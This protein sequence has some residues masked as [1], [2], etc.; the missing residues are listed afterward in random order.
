MTIDVDKL[1]WWNLSVH[2]ASVRG[3]LS[4]FLDGLRPSGRLPEIHTSLPL[5][6]FA[7]P[8]TPP[9]K[10]SLGPEP[11]TALFRRFVLEHVGGGDLAICA[12]RPVAGTST[13]SD[14]SVGRAWDWQVRIDRPD[15]VKRV[16]TL[17]AW[18]L[19]NNAEYARRIGIRTIIWNKQI[20]SSTT[21]GRWA[22]YGGQSPHQDHVHFSLS[23]AG[24]SASTSFFKWLSAGGTGVS[25]LPL[26]A[27]FAFG[28][29]GAF[30][31]LRSS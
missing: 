27:G 16:N 24:A 17:F 6:P 31:L 10:C 4:T 8:E 20:W 1:C 3:P 13:L 26:A 21:G 11:G 30:L 22:P 29:G 5:E 9:T 15:D 18:L 7:G 12:C 28:V 14:H 25:W 19:K 2:P 23:A